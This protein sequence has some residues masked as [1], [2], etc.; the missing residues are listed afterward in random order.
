MLIA[1][2]VMASVMIAPAAFAQT[3][4]FVDTAKVLVSYKGAQSASAQVQKELAALQKEFG[5]RQK[6]IQDAQKSGKSQAELQKL[7]E[8]YEKELI[9]LKQRAAQLDA[10]LSADVRTKIIGQIQAIAKKRKVDLVLDKGAVYYGGVDL[11]DDVIKAL[12]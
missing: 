4:G 2:A 9:P 1:S 12:K 11:T 7:I 6:K 5:E 3:I 10:R 8:Q